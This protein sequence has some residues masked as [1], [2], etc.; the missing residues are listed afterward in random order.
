[1][2]D[3]E[4]QCGHP[5]Q[6]PSSVSAELGLSPALGSEFCRGFYF[7]KS[8]LAHWIGDKNLLKGSGEISIG[9][10]E[11]WPRARHDEVD[12]QSY[13]FREVSCIVIE[14]PVSKRFAWHILS[15]ELGKYVV[16]SQSIRRYWRIEIGGQVYWGKYFTLVRDSQNT[17]VEC[18]STTFMW[19]TF[20]RHLW[21]H[22]C[23][24]PLC[25][26]VLYKYDTA[27]GLLFCGAL[28]WVTL[29]RPLL[30]IVKGKPWLLDWN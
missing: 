2:D 4:V 10:M 9:S 3:P 18:Y 21:G 13:S 28:F 12:L 23:E 6:L 20:V 24:T 5:F 30:Y 27:I 15:F 17:L 7:Q 14:D 22:Y 8:G 1:M 29:G 19:D 26:T 16:S 11:T 25:G